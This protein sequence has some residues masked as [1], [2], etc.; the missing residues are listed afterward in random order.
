MRAG[1]GRFKGGTLHCRHSIKIHLRWPLLSRHLILS[2]RSPVYTSSL[3]PASPAFRGSPCTPL[4]RRGRFGAWA[5]FRKGWAGLHTSWLRPKEA[6]GSRVNNFRQSQKLNK[7]ASPAGFCAKHLCNLSRVEAWIWKGLVERA[8]W[9]SLGSS[10]CAF[11]TF[12]LWP[13]EQPILL[14]HP[15]SLLKPP[16]LVSP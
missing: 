11:G 2:L 8:P 6:P 4:G 1:S 16:T 5:A 10:E 9:M 15:R 3:G 14:L 7:W 13:P 12:P